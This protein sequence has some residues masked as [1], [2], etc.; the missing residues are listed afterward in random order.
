MPG[1]LT[2]VGDVDGNSAYGGDPSPVDAPAPDQPI[3]FG[4]DFDMPAWIDG[5]EVEPLSPVSTGPDSVFEQTTVPRHLRRQLRVLL[6]LIE[7]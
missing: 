4:N 5:V 3:F 1:V 6:S 2:V 7:T